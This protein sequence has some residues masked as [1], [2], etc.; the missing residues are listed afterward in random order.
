MKK[1]EVSLFMNFVG[2]LKRKEICRL[3]STDE[4]KK[5]KTTEF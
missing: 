4:A 1:P 3:L 2:V 5:K